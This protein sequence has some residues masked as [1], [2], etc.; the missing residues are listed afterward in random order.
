MATNCVNV[1]PSPRALRKPLPMPS[2]HNYSFYRKCIRVIIR[3]LLHEENFEKYQRIF[4]QK[5]H[6]SQTQYLRDSGYILKFCH[7]I[8]L[9]V[10]KTEKAVVNDSPRVRSYISSSPIGTAGKAVLLVKLP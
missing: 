5:L 3:V 8:I 7:G 1:L 4:R 10:N 2:V 6:S 9:N